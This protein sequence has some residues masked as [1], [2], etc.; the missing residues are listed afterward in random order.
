ME[1]R[2]KNPLQ[3]PLQNTG[4]GSITVCLSYSHFKTTSLHYKKQSRLIRSSPCVLVCVYVSVSTLKKLT[5]LYE[6]QCE[7]YDT[8]AHANTLLFS[9]LQQLITV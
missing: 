6:I 2:V 3:G 9:S 8:G 5:I 7:C 4:K 1:Y